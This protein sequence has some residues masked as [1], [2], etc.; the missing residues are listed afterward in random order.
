MPKKIVSATNLIVESWNNYRRHFLT[1]FELVAWYLVL[2]VAWWGLKI[3]SEQVIAT[4]GL[5]WGISI[6]ALGAVILTLIS[7]YA[8]AVFI[9]IVDD[10]LSARATSVVSSVMRVKERYWS[11]VAASLIVLAMFAALMV[12]I[13]TPFALPSLLSKS[14]SFLYLI[15]IGLLIFPFPA[16][17]M[18]MLYNFFPY[19]AVI[20]GQRPNDSVRQSRKLVSGR[21]WSVTWRIIAIMALCAVAMSL[22]TNLLLIVPGTVMGDPGKYIGPNDFASMTGAADSL[23]FELAS[24][25]AAALTLPFLLA[26][27]ISLWKDLKD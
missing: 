24:S 12:V 14:G 16:F 1:Y 3:L 25:V 22:I 9:T 4:G 15:A 19:F 6:F 13:F 20:D 2:G 8:S 27:E 5:I 18:V 11:F 7:T 21:F 23:F 10:H 26:S 17:V